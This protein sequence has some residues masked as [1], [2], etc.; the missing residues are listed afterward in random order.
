MKNNS[1]TFKII[2]TKEFKLKVYLVKDNKE[3]QIYLQDN[4][5]EEYFPSILFDTNFIRICQE[6]DT[7]IN[8]LQDLF[9]RPNDNKYYTVAFQLKEYQL[10]AE[11]LFALDIS[12]FKQIV[13]K[14]NIIT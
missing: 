5:K 9:N 7:S 11:V 4:K 2:I 13:E 8:F 6:S 3:I 14:E 12:E 1:T 10:I